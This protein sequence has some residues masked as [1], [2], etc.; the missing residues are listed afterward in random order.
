MPSAEALRQRLARHGQE[1]VLRFW[2][3]LDQDGRAR[4][5]G[6]LETLDLDQLDALIEELV[7][8]EAAPPVDPSSAEEHPVVRL[9]EQTP[10]QL[11]G[12]RQL[13]S[14]ALG[15]GKVAALCVAGGQGTRLGYDAPKGTYPIGPI[16]GASLFQLHAE[17]I[18][19][20]ERRHG[21]RIPLLV[22][23]SPANHEATAAF[24]A[25]HANFGLD[26]VRLFVQGTMPAVDRETGKLLLAGKDRL[27][28]SPDGHGGTL[29]ALAA[30]PAGGG[31]SVLDE[32]VEWG[33]ETLFYFQVD[34]ALV[35]IA[36]PGFL[37]LHLDAGVELS[38]KVVEKIDPA[39]KVGLVVEAGGV[40]QIIEYSDMPEELAQRR[41]PDGGLALWAG[42]IA[43]HI[44]QRSFVER[45]VSGDAGTSLPFHRADK[46]V[47]HVDEHGETV[48][49]DEPNA[50]K[51]EQFVFDALPLAGRCLIV[52]TDRN[53]FAPLKN[54]TGPDSAESA[55]AL[56]TRLHAGWLRQAGAD[57]ETDEVEISPLVALDADDL[58]GRIPPG[59]R[60]TE[61]L[62]LD[63]AALAAK[64]R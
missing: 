6:Q 46:K 17:R 25:E 29:R 5:A 64:A 45:L 62:Y 19:A 60:V 11:A 54:A 53:E 40:S 20:L 43:I 12:P 61:P 27:A 52:E 32:L 7:R 3:E 41:R 8:G 63:E 39:E 2:D 14:E 9:T 15:A 21:G 50:V 26:T 49:P 30:K 31:P 13:G 16:S 56:M 42:S 57:V 24:F 33:V 44:L 36:D 34:N 58:D 1:H 55:R 37:G 48:E 47:A 18:L 59:L 35:K 10:E 23:T 22:M 28:L 4:L 38:S 51:F